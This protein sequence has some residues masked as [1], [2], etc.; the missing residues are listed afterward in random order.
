MTGPLKGVKVVE[1]AA[2]GPVPLAGMLL[3]DLGADIVRI[4]RTGVATIDPDDIASRG[5]RFVALD[6][7]DPA[8]IEDALRLIGAADVLMEGFR[9]GVMERLGLGPDIVAARNPGLVYG[10]MTGWGQDGPLAKAAGH[11]IN[12][13]ALTG[14]LAAIGTPDEPVPPLNLIGDYAG[15]TMY[16]VM[17]ILAALVERQASGRGQVIDCAMVDSVPGLLTM[18]HMLARKGRQVE[19]RQSNFLDGGAHFYRTYKCADGRFMSVGA[20][21]PQFYAELR[22]IAGLDDPAFDAQW[23]T[24]AWP[25]LRERMARVFAAR[26]QAE[27]S[28]LFEGTDACVAPVLTM[29]EAP[30]HA[31]MAARGVFAE[32]DGKLE[33]SP[34]PRFSRS[35][36]ELPGKAAEAATTVGT[37]LDGWGG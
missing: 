28:G 29:S 22:R 31:H 8:G 15:G 14:A 2:I 11:D 12:Y 20:I 7:K 17:G 32:R 21:E 34:A 16:L 13:I 5:R 19:A 36:L 4:E 3:A 37:V 10:R 1:F 30:A 27:W 6:L 25:A 9:P 24:A 26:T 18:F 33:A 35:T 23:D